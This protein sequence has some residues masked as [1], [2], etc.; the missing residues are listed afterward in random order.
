M[1]ASH[2]LKDR[3]V[4]TNDTRYL[5][6]V[7]D[8][9]ARVLK[10]A[11]VDRRDEN[12]IILAVDE[13]VS[14]VI[15]HGYPS[16]Q[17]GTI[18]IEVDSTDAEVRVVIHDQG[19]VFNPESVSEPDIYEHVKVGRKKGLGIFLMRQIMDEVCY[20]FRDGV[21]NELTLIKYLK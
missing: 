14:N 19:R 20:R 15:E 7:R 17:R 6:L 5:A 9:V 18:E 11:R 13:A 21:K 8:F 3:L 16:G 12:K 10:Y 4:V 2:R 1:T